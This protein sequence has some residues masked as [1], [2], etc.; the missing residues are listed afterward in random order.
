MPRVLNEGLNGFGLL[1]E[2]A[3]E[4]GVAFGDF[5]EVRPQIGEDARLDIHDGDVDGIRFEGVERALEGI[6]GKVDGGEVTAQGDGAKQF[7]GFPEQA[8][9]A[10]DVKEDLARL[11]QFFHSGQA[12]MGGGM[13]AVAEGE[14]GL[15]LK[16]EAVVWSWMIASGRNE[17]PTPADC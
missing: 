13:V 6:A 3:A 15:Q 17:K 8:G 4:D 7:R 5:G 10:A 2:E 12:E 1:G 14:P 11:D 16:P 9:A